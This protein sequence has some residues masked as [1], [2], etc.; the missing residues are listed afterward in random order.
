MR[1]MAAAFLAVGASAMRHWMSGRAADLAARY[2]PSDVRNCQGPTVMGKA[3]TS[4][5][6]DK[7][8]YKCR[9]RKD[10]RMQLDNDIQT[11]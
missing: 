4:M 9:V 7:S 8:N 5:N 2:N 10:I 3:R 6:S 11:T 1:P